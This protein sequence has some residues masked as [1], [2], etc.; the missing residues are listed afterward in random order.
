MLGLNRNEV[1][2]VRALSWLLRPGSQHG[3]GDLVVA[4]LL[5]SLGVP[6]THGTPVDVRREERHD[7]GVGWVAADLL[8]RTAG[9]C[10]LPLTT[11]GHLQPCL[12]VGHDAGGRPALIRR[13]GG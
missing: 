10:V 2:M 5:E 13:R 1:V 8:L 7:T 6:Y 12:P 11:D 9:Q 3:L 4:R